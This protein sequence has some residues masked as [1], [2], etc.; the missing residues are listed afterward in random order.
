MGFLKE[1]KKKL[2]L[3]G[4]VCPEVAVFL[5]KLSFEM[6]F[7]L[8][9]YVSL[10]CLSC[11]SYSHHLPGWFFLLRVLKYFKVHAYSFSTYILY[12]I[13]FRESANQPHWTAA[14]Q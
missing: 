2:N 6:T 11:L 1:Q 5:K 10:L 3:Y 12:L 4:I 14:S 9:F 7:L 8:L 13:D